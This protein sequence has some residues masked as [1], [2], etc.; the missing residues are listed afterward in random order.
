[1]NRHPIILIVSAPS[2][3]GKGTILKEVFEGKDVFMSVSC[4]T[5]DPREN[6]IDGKH[7]HFWSEEKFNKLVEED[8]FLEHAGFSDNQYGTPAQPV[9]DNIAAGRDVILE[10]ETNGAFQIK[11]KRPD[12]VS[13]FILPPSIGELRR[14]LYKRGTETPEKIE[15]RLSRAA[16][17]I[18]LAKDYDF[19]MMNDDLDA[20]VVD[21]ITIYRAAKNNDGSA[22]RF[23]PSNEETKNMINEVLENA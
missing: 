4:T 7:Y 11:K 1:M 17:E 8:G 5:R 19:V 15:K 3:C 21:F 9:F 13:L 6:E 16:G 23:R 12:A 10:I 22:D 14:R 18:G 2:G 20:A